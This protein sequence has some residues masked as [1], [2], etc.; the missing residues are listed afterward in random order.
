MVFRTGTLAADYFGPVGCAVGPLQSGQVTVIYLAHVKTTG[1]ALRCF[2][3]EENILT[4]QVPK[5]IN[6]KPT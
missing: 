1:V 2:P 4:V 5:N 3:A 6:I